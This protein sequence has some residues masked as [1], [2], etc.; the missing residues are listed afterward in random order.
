MQNSSWNCEVLD[1]WKDGLD[2]VQFQGL[3]YIRQYKKQEKCKYK[4]MHPVGL[5][6]AIHLLE[7]HSV[8]AL[9]KTRLTVPV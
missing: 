4:S 5:K 6:P 7:L 1:I 8:V 9:C 3:S 2:E